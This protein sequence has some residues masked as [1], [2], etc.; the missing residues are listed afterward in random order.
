M[1][2]FNGDNNAALSYHAS[3]CYKILSAL[4]SKFSRSVPVFLRIFNFF[5]RQAISKNSSKPLIVKGFYLLRMPNDCRFRWHAQ[6]QLPQCNSRNIV[7]VLRTVVKSHKC[8]KGTKVFACGCFGRNPK[9]FSKF[10]GNSPWWSPFI[11]K[12]RPVTAFKRKQG[13]DYS[14][15]SIKKKK[16]WKKL[17]TRLFCETVSEIMSNKKFII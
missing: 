15:K 14:V 17:W 2:F 8:L 7:T 5:F 6:G 4:L 10:A 12:L 1:K 13:K 16:F 9:N 11:V 3:T